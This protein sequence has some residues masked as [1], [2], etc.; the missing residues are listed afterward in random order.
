MIG[1]SWRDVPDPFTW[2][3]CWSNFLSFFK[4]LFSQKKKRKIKPFI[5][6]PL[7]SLK[8][9]SLTWKGG[10]ERTCL[11]HSKK[12]I[13]FM[14]ERG[15]CLLTCTMKAEDDQGPNSEISISQP[16]LKSVPLS[17]L[18]SQRSLTIKQAFTPSAC[19]TDWLGQA[20]LEHF[21]FYKYYPILKVNF[22]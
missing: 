18:F 22:D 3:Y 10:E 7:Q 8:Q 16:P 19:Q 11:P 2:V 4:L 14:K 6:F 15:H 17:T 13:S 9:L 21:R 1:S 20:S 12:L 5:F